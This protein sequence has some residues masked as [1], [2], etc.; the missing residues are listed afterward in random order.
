MTLL[1]KKIVNNDLW[2]QAMYVGWLLYGFSFCLDLYRFG[3][4]KRK[5]GC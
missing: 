5:R 4:E 2:F 1:E 3:I